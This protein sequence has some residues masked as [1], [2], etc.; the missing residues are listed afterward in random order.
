MKGE[1]MDKG[2]LNELLHQLDAELENTHVVDDESR[3]LLRHLQG[4]IQV[5]LKQTST[6]PRQY[7]FLSKQLDAAFDR[8]EGSHPNLAMTIKQLIDHLAQV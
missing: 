2:R 4:D 5:A 1:T 6:A 7:S 3:Q 8:F